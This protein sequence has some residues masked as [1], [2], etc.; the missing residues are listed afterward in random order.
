MNERVTWLLPVKNGMPYIRETLASIECQTYTNWEI[1]VWDNGSTDGTLEE[2]KNWI[3]HRLPGRIISDRP[4][5]LGNSLA[6][7]VEAASTEFC[8]RIDADDLNYP[9]RLEKQVEYTRRN[10]RVGVVGTQF[11]FID[12]DGNEDPGAWRQPLTDAEIRWRFRW[13]NSLNHC[14]VL[15]RRSVVIAA[16]NYQDCMPYEDYDLWIRMSV[17]CEMAN[18]PQ[19]L[20]KYRRLASS[21][22]DGGRDNPLPLFEAVADRNPSILFGGMEP[23]AALRFR[24]RVSISSTDEVKLGD[25]LALRRAARAT[26]VWLG[27]PSNYFSSTNLY[28]DQLIHLRSR[29]LQKT[30]AGRVILSVKRGL[31]NRLRSDLKDQ[32][33]S[34]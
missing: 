21:V 17:L 5:S 8:A 23:E 15:F 26:A 27:K 14:S 6:A 25:I 7:L 20:F 19:A 13:A 28:S 16:G 3:P 22:T 34:R 4:L 12:K 18:L 24:R 32:V 10:P 2:L 29:Y 9:T 11:D 33:A 1:I 30:S 31:Q